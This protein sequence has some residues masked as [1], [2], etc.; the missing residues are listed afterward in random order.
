MVVGLMDAQ[1][2]KRG[3]FFALGFNLDV[4]DHQ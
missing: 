3:D 4:A 1:P 2:K